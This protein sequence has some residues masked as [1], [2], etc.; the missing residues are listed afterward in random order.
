M[1]GLKLDLDAQLAFLEQSLPAPREEFRPPLH[2]L[3]PGVFGLANPMYGP[4]DADVLYA[5]VR[6][7]SPQTVLEL[8]SGFSSAV[9]AEALERNR[10][11]GAQGRH[12]IVDP[13]PSPLLRRLDPQPEVSSESA[14]TIEAE[15]F[16]R[17]RAGDLL[18]VDTS[19]VVKPGSEVLRVVFEVLPLL[20]PG[21]VIHFHDIFAPF[22]YPRVLYD[23]Y[24]VHWQEQ[25]LLQAF[26]SFNPHFTVLCAN[27]ALWR[28]RR[29]Q[30]SR[31]FPA[32]RPGM[33]PSGFWFRRAA[34]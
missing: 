1:P 24:D 6:H 18:F 19:H 17:L 10:A 27:H 25:Y 11:D 4:M 26:L 23:E 12:E 2:S 22:P 29:E 32:L 33:E 31:L 16:M 21:V 28:L 20:A 15:R 8:G 13:Y 9:I 7:H 14:A 34:V 5:M 3:E 30:V